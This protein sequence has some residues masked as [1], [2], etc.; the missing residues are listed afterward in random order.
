MGVQPDDVKAADEPLLD[1]DNRDLPMDRP[2]EEEHD[3]ARLLLGAAWYQVAARNPF[4][5]TYT[6]LFLAAVDA[7][8]T[9]A[10]DRLLRL[11]HRDLVDDVSAQ[12]DHAATGALQALR[13]TTDPAH[14]AGGVMFV[15]IDI[16]TDADLLVGGTLIETCD[17]LSAHS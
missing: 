6:P 9:F 3:L 10:L 13:A 15:G 2:W 11:S 12:L 5:F 14:C 16:T 17:G 7:P 1:L 4:G 8:K